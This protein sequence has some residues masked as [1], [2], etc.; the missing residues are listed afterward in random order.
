LQQCHTPLVGGHTTEGSE[1]AVGLACNGLVCEDRI[2][3]KSG[4]KPSEVLILTKALG[5]GTLFAAEM[6]SKAQGRWIDGAVESMLLSNQM[7]AQLFLEWGATACT[8][9]T[10]FGLVGHLLEMV[11]A[12]QV[13][14]ELDLDAIP[15]LEGAIEM[16][17]QEITSSLHSQNFQ[18]SA[19]IRNS[20]R[21]QNSPSYQLLFDPQTAGG[22]LAAVPADRAK[23]CLKALHSS[24]YLDSQ[25]IGCVVPAD[26]GCAD[27]TVGD[28]PIG[29]A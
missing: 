13:G 24:G 27:L 19:R 22:L 4:M 15:A 26:N 18:F 17:S 23:D 21:G 29:F 3:R 28:R 10:G 1:L 14:V 20:P 6:R 16:I 5:T 8:D 2:L 9:V 12:S 25:I 11:R 7:A